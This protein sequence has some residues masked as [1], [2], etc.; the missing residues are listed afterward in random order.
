MMN[1]RQF[2]HHTSPAALNLPGIFECTKAWAKNKTQKMIISRTK[3][4]A[5]MK[6]ILFVDFYALQLLKN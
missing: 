5:L 2:S 4:A 6:I 1:N 3:D